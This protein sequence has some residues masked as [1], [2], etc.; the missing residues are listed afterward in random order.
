MMVSG[1]GFWPLVSQA[2]GRVR[3]HLGIKGVVSSSVVKHMWRSD[4]ISRTAEGGC[5]WQGAE[6]NSRQHLQRTTVIPYKKYG[7]DHWKNTNNQLQG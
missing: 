1:G 2:V 5:I 7:R 6:V 3:N 4:S